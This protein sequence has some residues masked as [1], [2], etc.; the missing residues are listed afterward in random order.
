[1]FA[2]MA[3]GCVII[4]LLDHQRKM[5]SL[6]RSDRK[7][8]E[9]LDTRVDAL[10]AEIRELKSMLAADNSRQQDDNLTQRIR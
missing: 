7:E 3:F 9:G 4:A 2:F 10:Q 1:M 6:L 8:T 5:A